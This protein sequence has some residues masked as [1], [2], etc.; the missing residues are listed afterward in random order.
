V[1]CAHSTNVAIT[2][3]VDRR[4]SQRHVPVA[5]VGAGLSGLAAAYELKARGIKALVFEAHRRFG[6]RVL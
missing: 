6:G 3:D 1:R 4:P 5:V 2:A